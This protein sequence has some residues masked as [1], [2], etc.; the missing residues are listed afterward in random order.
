MNTMMELRKCCI[1][2]FLINNA[3]EQITHEFR[4]TKGPE[5]TQFQ[6]MVQSSGKLVLID[7][8]LPRLKEDGHRVLIFSQMVRCLD[9]LEDYLIQ[10]R[11]PFERID[12]RVRGSLRQAAIDRYSKPGSDRFVFLLCT[13]AGGL[14]INLTAADTVII[15]DSDWNPQNDLQAQARCHR[16]GQKKMVKIYRLICRNTYEREMFD[17]ASLKLGLD[18]AVLQSMNTDKA[19]KSG[20]LN[21]GQLSKK[22][23]EDLL[24]KGA[25]GALM[26][27][28]NA[29]DKFCEED[30]EQILKR[31]TQVVTIESVEEKGSTFS[32]ASFVTSDRSDIELDDPHFWEKFAKK[33]NFDVEEVTNRNELIVEEPRRRVQTRRFGQ[34]DAI[35]DAISDPESNSD[36]DDDDDTV[37]GRTRGG[38][39]G[40]SKRDKKNKR[41][42]TSYAERPEEIM[43]EFSLSNC[44]RSECYKVEKGLLTFGWNRWDE[45]MEISNFR[46][47]LEAK[48]IEEL[49]RIIVLFCCQNYKGDEKIKNF[50]YDLVS[51]PHIKEELEKKKEEL[52]NSLSKRKRR[53][54]KLLE[55]EQ[56]KVESEKLEWLKDQAYNPD[57]LLTDEQYRKHLLRHANKV[58]LRI[59]LLNYVKYDI[60]GSELIEQIQ[61]GANA[62][63]LEILSLTPDG[64]PMTDWWDEEADKSLVVGIYKHGFDHYNAMRLDSTL[65]FLEKCG[66]PDGNAWLAE[67]NQE[68]DQE[69]KQIEDID[70]N[71]KQN[72]ENSKQNDENSKQNADLSTLPKET[73]NIDQL[74][75]NVNGD[76][77]VNETIAMSVDEQPVVE[78]KNEETK[79]DSDECKEPVTENAI[80][81]VNEKSE[82]KIEN[83]E[84]IE[85]EEKIENEEKIEDEE[86]I[87]DEERIKDKVEKVEEENIQTVDIK[88]EAKEEEMIVD[89][90]VKTEKKDELEENESKELKEPETVENVEKPEE[91]K[92]EDEIIKDE[93]TTDLQ[94]IQENVIKTEEI[95]KLD[96]EEVQQTIDETTAGY[97]LFPSASDLN[98]RL[99]KIVTAHQR[100][101]KKQELKLAQQAKFQQRLEKIEKNEALTREKE[102]KKREQAQKKWSRREENE[103]C[104]VVSMFGVEYN[105]K[106]D[107]YNWNRFRTFNKFDKKMDDTLTEY[108]KAFYAMC[109]RVTNKKLTSEEENLPISVDTISEDKA[110]RC[111]ARIDLLSRIREAL[112]HKKFEDRLKLCQ[113]SVDLP[114]WWTPGKHDKDLLTGTAKYGLNR[115]DYNLMNDQDL[116]FKDQVKLE[117]AKQAQQQAT[118][119]SVLNSIG[120][121]A[122]ESSINSTISPAISPAINPAINP[123]ITPSITPSIS[124]AISPAVDLNLSIPNDTSKSAIAS[125]NKEKNI[126]LMSKVID[127]LCDNEQDVDSWKEIV[128]DALNTLDNL[129]DSVVM[130]PPERKSSRDSILNKTEDPDYSLLSQRSLMKWPKDRIL[131]TRMEHICQ[132]IET[133]EW[134]MKQSFFNTS[135]LSLNSTL[136]IDSSSPKPPLSPGSLSG[137]SSREQTPH[138]TPDH[139]PRRSECNS[140]TVLLNNNNNSNASMSSSSLDIS[141]LS[142]PQ[143]LEEKS[144]KRRRK[145]NLTITSSIVNTST[146]NLNPSHLSTTP[147]STTTTTK[148]LTSTSQQSSGNLISNLQTPS[149]IEQQFANQ[150][151]SSQM[152]KQKFSKQQLAQQIQQQQIQQQ[153]Q[154]LQQQLSSSSSNN[155]KKSS[156]SS[157]ANNNNS[158]LANNPLLKSLFPPLLGNL[159]GFGG[160][161]EQQ[162]ASASSSNNNSNKGNLNLSNFLNDEKT[163]SFLLQ[164]ALKAKASGMNFNSALLQ[165]LQ[166]AASGQQQQNQQQQQQQQQKN[167]QQQNQQ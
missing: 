67:L 17:K 134:P 58:I 76:A 63:D 85:D 77:S 5:I 165:A 1:H 27:D 113:A 81:I 92:K 71:S 70:E 115:L 60:L 61:N 108:Y 30:I 32:K 36:G 3:E 87:K 130:N 46:R 158:N 107:R 66:P 152:G 65:C 121:V 37:S 75:N 95:T 122:G 98:Q 64:E 34:D 11:Y 4:E 73:E 127:E 97:L 68:D 47:K 90:E 104:K 52:L 100:N 42:R 114:S 53:K 150:Q 140:P 24:K 51:P 94:S 39:G 147:N 20:G 111:L 91:E 19:A 38:R 40:K 8:L 72:D 96:G 7:K 50:A 156:S 99:R 163:A 120:K 112:A 86:K 131:I 117:E 124:S 166:A 62:K 154:M 79:L 157:T 49:A 25:Y 22:E 151:H 21:D 93:T 59:K 83:D 138:Q 44:T 6:T 135:T 136:G 12:G 9:I 80:E 110:S 10:K 145:G 26:D 84:K 159:P 55:E 41:G 15:F 78:N 69:G 161:N 43:V 137:L 167:Q 35:L 29:G 102:N 54:N 162:T 74:L 129:I 82:E 105:K 89:T 23:I 123:A 144:R 139:T 31:R 13:R 126:R 56:E 88:E 146:P 143:P 153:Q 164:S 160:Q 57:L 155:S 116:S 133:N 2:P 118:T 28:D 125:L 128:S 101:F 16:I 103:F 148:K 119:Q 132:C 106:K 18:K 141:T 109:K 45:I 149:L 142:T 33:A 14:G 48:D